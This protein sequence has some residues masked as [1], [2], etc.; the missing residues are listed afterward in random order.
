MLTTEEARELPREIVAV[1]GENLWNMDE[2]RQLA[3]GW[4]EPRERRSVGGKEARPGRDDQ[5]VSDPRRMTGETIIGAR[6]V[7]VDVVVN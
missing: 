5:L 4:T 2:I 3:S 6:V 1:V 7:V